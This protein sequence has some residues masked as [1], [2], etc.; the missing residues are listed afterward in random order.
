M[1][2]RRLLFV[3]IL[4]SF[5]NDLTTDYARQL[6]NSKQR[7]SGNS[8]WEGEYSFGETGGKNTGLV[9]E[10]SIR[11][12]RKDGA[13]MADIDADGHQT[14]LRLSCKADI[15]SNRITFRFNNYREENL[16]E[17]YQP[18]EVLLSLE[19]KTGR[20]LTYWGALRPQLI[21]YKSGRVYFYR[22]AA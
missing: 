9:I 11:I 5:C 14:L 19:R 17:L 16:F 1:S 6:S 2:C 3:I 7:P 21:S 22:K 8:S 10:Y 4:L 13:L 20:L 15:Q 18:G 12:Y